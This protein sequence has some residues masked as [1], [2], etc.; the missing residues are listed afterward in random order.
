MVSWGIAQLRI[1]V[2]GGICTT[3]G[4]QQV[5]NQQ[6]EARVG[7]SKAHEERSKAPVL[8]SKDRVIK[9]RD[10]EQPPINAAQSTRNQMCLTSD[11][12]FDDC[13]RVGY[14]RLENCKSYD[15]LSVEVFLQTETVAYA[16]LLV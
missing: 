15:H 5:R 11:C 7:Q 14:R 10:F 6:E 1:Q 8:M 3:E 13:F 4:R 2:V 16:L 9:E 12:C